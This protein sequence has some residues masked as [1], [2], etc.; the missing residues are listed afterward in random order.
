LPDDAKPPLPTF[1]ALNPGVF[2][3]LDRVSEEA[4]AWMKLPRC[5]EDEK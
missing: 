4:V 2:G 1:A 3:A 5:E